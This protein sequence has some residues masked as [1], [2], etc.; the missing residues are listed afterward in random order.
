MIIEQKTGIWIGADRHGVYDES[1]ADGLAHFCLAK[2]FATIVDLGCGHGKY[3]E[4][5][6]RAGLNCV[7]YD[8][9][10][11]TPQITNG[12]CRVLNLARP[13]SI[14]LFDCVISLEVGEHIPKDYQEI[15]ICNL[16]KTT[17]KYLIC[18]W[19][20]PGQGGLGHFNERPQQEVISDFEA[21]GRLHYDG[22]TSDMLR[23]LSSLPWFKNTII[24]FRADE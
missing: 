3:V 24:C 13:I 17:R 11:F 2:Q 1:L 22:G 18:S 15:Y 23:E 8:G 14:G 20:L 7:G 9:N 6:S 4:H 12:K 5:L 16:L 21:A 10:P 19:A